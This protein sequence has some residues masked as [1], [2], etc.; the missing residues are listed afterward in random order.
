MRYQSC[1]R[2]RRVLRRDGLL[3]VIAPDSNHQNKGTEW[4]K[5]WRRGI[6]TAGFTRWRYEKTSHLHC[7]AFRAINV[8]SVELTDR[9]LERHHPLLAIPQDNHEAT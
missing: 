5:R 4:M 2:A 9:N 3:I 8:P 7:M 6:E 1:Q